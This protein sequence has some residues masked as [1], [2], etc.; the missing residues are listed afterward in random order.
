MATF[1]ETYGLSVVLNGDTYDASGT[2]D[3]TGVTK[4]FQGVLTIAS[5][6]YANLLT[7][8]STAGI[9]T[10]TTIKKI[11][12]KNNET[13]EGGTT[14][15]IRFLVT[16]GKEY[17]RELKAGSVMYIESKSLDANTDG[18]AFD[19]LTDINTISAAGDG[20][21]VSLSVVACGT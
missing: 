21:T 12:I 6:T 4:A 18:A 7:V 2:K 19:A 9:A 3:I 13:T 10:L 11:M 8:T 1:Q 20:A 14:A 5:A 17:I 16:G 15:R